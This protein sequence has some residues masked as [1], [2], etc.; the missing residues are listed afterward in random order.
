MTQNDV[1]LLVIDLQQGLFKKSTPIYQAE[2]L[3]QNVTSL[4]ALAHQRRIPVFYVQHSDARSLV[5]GTPDWQLHA[6]LT[7]LDTDYVVHKQ[8]GNAFE[9]TTLHETL[10][11]KAITTVV[12][13]GLVTHG[14]VRATCLGARQLGYRVILVRDGHSSFSK[15]AAELIEEW[16]QKLGA[17]GVEIKPAAEITFD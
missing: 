16:N 2:E 3:L 13:T 9:K 7:P 5:K 14:C 8:H 17:E 15:Q 6:R 11:S 1:A 12:I 4:I 10:R